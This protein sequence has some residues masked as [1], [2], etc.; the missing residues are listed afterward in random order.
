MKILTLFADETWKGNP[1]VDVWQPLDNDLENWAKAHTWWC[2]RPWALMLSQGPAE[3]KAS[4]V[5]TGR[6]FRGV[7]G[8]LIPSLW[9]GG[10]P[11][12]G[13]KLLPEESGEVFVTAP[14]R[15]TG[16]N[17]G[18]RDGGPVESGPRATAEPRGSK[19]GQQRPAGRPCGGCSV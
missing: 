12:S 1:G 11:R 10:R 18:P 6:S 19:M 15:E 13:G 3:S 4:A 5:W 9:G 2:W 17:P 8:R 7:E 16:R 14:P